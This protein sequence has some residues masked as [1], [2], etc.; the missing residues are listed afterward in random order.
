MYFGAPSVGSKFYKGKPTNKPWVNELLCQLQTR[1]EER[2]IV[3]DINRVD[4]ETGEYHAGKATHCGV[5]RLPFTGDQTWSHKEMET[6]AQCVR[7]NGVGRGLDIGTYDEC[8]FILDSL[9]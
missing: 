1:A 3:K 8:L 5:K 9:V 4:L 2:S 6:L 7:D